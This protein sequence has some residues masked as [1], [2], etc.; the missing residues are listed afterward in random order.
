MEILSLLITLLSGLAG[1]HAAAA[2]APTV[3]LGKLGNSISGVLG[4]GL[5]AYALQALDLLN[6]SGVLNHGAEAVAPGF[7]LGALLAHIG[8]SGIGGALLTFIVGYLRNATQK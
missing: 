2:V 4:G 5:G 7:D 1:G 3:D 6:K 8:S